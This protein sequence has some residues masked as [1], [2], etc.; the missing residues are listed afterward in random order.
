MDVQQALSHATE[1][2]L[3][4]VSRGALSKVPDALRKLEI[5]GPLV[6]VAD[7]NTYR[8][9][10][11]RLATFLKDAG[12]VLTEPIVFPGSPI[13]HA[14]YS[15]IIELRE[16]LGK[17]AAFPIAVGSGT[18]NDLVKRSIWELDRRY[19]SVGTAVSMDGYTSA[20]AAILKDGF[21]QTLEC[22]APL[23]IIGDL[24][25]LAAAPPKMTAAGYGD[26]F[27]KIVAGADWI[28][29]DAIGADPIDP[30]AWQMVQDDLREWLATP[31]ACAKG[32]PDSIASLYTGL[33]LT[34]FAMQ[35]IH[36]SRPASGAEHQLSHIW[37]M[38]GLELDGEPVSHGLKV[39]I[40]S[41]VTCALFELLLQVDLENFDVDARLKSW[42][43]WEERQSEIRSLARGAS[44]AVQMELESKRKYIDH[45]ALRVRI[46]LL[47]SNWDGLR[48]RLRRQL[49]PYD[50]MREMLL[51]AGCPV[52]P[53]EIGLTRERAVRTI[54]LAQ[55][56]RER[57]TV[58]DLIY[59]LGLLG[60]WTERIYS[61]KRFW[62]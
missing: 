4:E 42:S 5:P 29:A 41:L 39:A 20:G 8:V 17:S 54:L 22:S 58:L 12:F 46:D 25:V 21:K 28:L 24:D 14:E 52:D 40:G 59:E 36:K 11:E 23:G 32:D 6:I 60:E 57:Y 55:M 56:M 45:E 2:R 3:F 1:T 37:E 62:R 43:S 35:A 38:E 49:Y 48:M 47:I 16:K 53:E 7:E 19:I 13:L 9:A 50:G 26:I 18:I 51:Q 31:S 27:A 30:L 10:G 44:Y 34:G 33:S 15:H 61:S